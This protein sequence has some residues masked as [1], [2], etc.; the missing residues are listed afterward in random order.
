MGGLQ[1]NLSLEQKLLN[2]LKELRDIDEVDLKVGSGIDSILWSLSNVA[3][4]VACHRGQLLHQIESLS[5][6]LKSRHYPR[7][8]DSMQD[9][10]RHCITPQDFGGLGYSMGDI[11]GDSE[12]SQVLFFVSAYLESL[13]YQDRQSSPVPSLDVRPA[14]H[15]GMS[16]PEKIFAAHDVAR[17]G[18]VRPGDVI[19]LDT[20]WVIASELS[21]YGME[22]TYENLGKPGIFRNDRLRIAGDHVVDP[23]VMKH[24]K[25][26]PLIYSSE[27]ARKVFKLTEYQV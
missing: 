9:F 20:D 3:E 5:H 15:R 24:P 1:E 11:L 18:E 6:S 14:G 4:Q 19:R 23:R 7:E 12:I 17:K 25:I 2:L 27:R 22:R 21:L 16:L 8:S 13:N 26:K 10:L